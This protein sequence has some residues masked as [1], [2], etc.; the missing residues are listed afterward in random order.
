V[1]VVVVPGLALPGDID[2]RAG[3]IGQI[4][5]EKGLALALSPEGG[6]E[7]R[8]G[9]DGDGRLLEEGDLGGRGGVVRP[10]RDVPGPEWEG[11]GRVC[12]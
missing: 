11:Q 12:R 8:K 6:D 1:V 7:E 3:A 5:V 9:V 2:M 10:G 4:D